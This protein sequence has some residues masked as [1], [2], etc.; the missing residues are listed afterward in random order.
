MI[1]EHQ[2][3]AP[4]TSIRIGGPADLLAQPKTLDELREVLS[5]AKERS[6]SVKI[7]GGGSNLVMADEG[8]RG[9]LIQPLLRDVR[10]LD[11]K[12][13]AIYQPG[14][15]AL[16]EQ[17]TVQAR[18]RSEQ[19][20]GF[21]HLEDRG[22]AITLKDPVLVEMGAAV[23]WGQ[24]VISSLQQNLAGLHWF[25]RIPCH[26]GG[27]TYNNIHAEHHF[28]SE[29]VC[30]VHVLDRESGE[31]RVLMAGDLEFGYD[32]SRFHHESSVITSVILALEPVTPEEA[33]FCQSQ[34]LEWTAQ[35]NKIQPKEPNCG[36]VFKN[37]SF[38]EAS[39]IGQEAVAA[40][41][42]IDQAGLKGKQIGGLQVYPGHANFIINTGGGTQV[43]FIQLVTE[44][45]E[46]VFEQFGV[47]VEPEVECCNSEGVSY[48]WLKNRS[49]GSF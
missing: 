36:S 49:T 28:L 48:T 42:Y 39:R 26:V 16:R 4:L 22:P 8:L 41:W 37:V 20:E 6:L 24:A 33:K 15:T 35:K 46:R 25:A 32:Y 5:L 9:L 44:I 14:L 21:L 23:P 13:Y 38:E 7:M 2:P 40:G 1:R 3:S 29:F 34:Y 12:E 43:D 19:G 31:E 18:Y 30:A 47:M 10:R 27:A 45:R 11:P 17:I